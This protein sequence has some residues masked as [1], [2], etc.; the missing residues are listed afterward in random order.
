[1][2]RHQSFLL[3]VWR[4]GHGRSR[5]EVEHIQT[6]EQVLARSLEDA[7]AWIEAR[8][9]GAPAP[10]GMEVPGGDAGDESERGKTMDG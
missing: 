7:L 9:A 3:R 1:M 6:G 2:G 5:V 10:A 4:L 8:S